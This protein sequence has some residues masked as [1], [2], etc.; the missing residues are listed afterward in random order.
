M[1]IHVATKSD[2]TLHSVAE[3]CDL[4]SFL[5]EIWAP[6]V[7]PCIIFLPAANFS[8]FNVNLSFVVRYLCCR[9]TLSQTE[10]WAVDRVCFGWLKSCSRL[11]AWELWAVGDT[12]ASGRVA[13]EEPRRNF[14]AG[15]RADLRT[16]GE[17]NESKGGGKWNTGVVV[18]AGEACDGNG[19][20]GDRQRQPLVQLEVHWCSRRSLENVHL[21]ILLHTGLLSSAEDSPRCVTRIQAQIEFWDIQQQQRMVS[22]MSKVRFISLCTM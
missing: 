4:V 18:G 20:A 21:G 19:V 1:L 5:F 15:Y 2:S 12:A 6:A 3:S 7:S 8:H 10:H 14:Q 11:T 9:M 13:T 17:K 22:K 16:L